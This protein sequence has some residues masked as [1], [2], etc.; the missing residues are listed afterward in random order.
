[1]ENM[2]PLDRKRPRASRNC[3]LSLIDTH[4]SI[5]IRWQKRFRSLRRCRR[6]IRVKSCGRSSL[7]RWSCRPTRLRRHAAYHAR[8]LNVLCGRNWAYRPIRPCGSVVSLGSSRSSGSISKI[9][10]TLQQRALRSAGR[11]SAFPCTAPGRREA[12]HVSSMPDHDQLG[13]GSQSG[14]SL[15]LDVLRKLVADRLL[16][17][18]R[19][20]HR[21]ALVEVDDVG[22]GQPKAS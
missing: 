11:L 2:L 6:F 21:H 1:M 22:I 4:T 5:D 8:G 14:F 18:H 13:P 7:F 16:H 3:R 17:D 9:A 15:E 20:A 19:R 10:M 12:R